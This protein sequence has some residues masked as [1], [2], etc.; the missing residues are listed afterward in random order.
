VY[1]LTD[2][3]KAVDV[4]PGDGDT[5]IEEMCIKGNAIPITFAELT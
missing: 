1:V 5:A 4:N 3:I 2:A